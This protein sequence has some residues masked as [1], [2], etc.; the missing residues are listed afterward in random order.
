MIESIIKQI[1]EKIP[2]SSGTSLLGFTQD[3][4]YT[5]GKSKDIISPY[6]I[7]RTEIPHRL[8][9]VRAQITDSVTDLQ[10]VVEAIENVWSSVMYRYFEAS[11]YQYYKEAAVFRFVTIIRNEKFFISGAIVLEGEK[12][13][14]LISDHQQ[15][16]KQSY[17]LLPSLMLPED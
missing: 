12:Y 16:I 10:I 9:T 1:A 11:S 6:K 17:D 2:P 8:V 5:L 3:L 15:K 4:D 13:H 14:S 7:S